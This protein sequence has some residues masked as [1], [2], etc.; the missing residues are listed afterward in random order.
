MRIS[1][2]IGFALGLAVA[3]LCSSLAYATEHVVLRPLGVLLTEGANTMAKFRAEVAQ[4]IANREEVA[5]VDSSLQR[6]SNGFRQDTATSR[7]PVFF[8]GA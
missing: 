7:A 8:P 6:D 1:R 3:S 4:A 5:K 2:S